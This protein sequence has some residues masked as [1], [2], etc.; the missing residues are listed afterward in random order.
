VLELEAQL[1]RQANALEAAALHATFDLMLLRAFMALVDEKERHLRDAADRELKYLTFMSHDMNNQL[2]AVSLHLRL[3]KDALATSGQQPDMTSI[4]GTVLR[5]IDQT[6]RSMRQLLDHESLRKG[7]LVARRTPVNL[8][9]M[10]NTIAMEFGPL[11]REK[12]LKVA[13]NADPTCEA[14]TDP[15]LIS[16]VLRNLI[17]NAVKYAQRGTIHIQCQSDP[18]APDADDRK[19]SLRIS[20]T[21][22]GPGIAAE[23]LDQIFHAFR[24]AESHGQPGVGLGLAIA[25]QSARLLEAELTVESTP[26]NGS[27]F[28]LRL[29]PA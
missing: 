21:D 14:K 5:G 13:V 28:H 19:R 16:L 22:Q 25:A 4:I 7:S 1:G 15:G 17:G 26:G 10:L 8:G 23:H 9:T 29:P 11:A 20:V 12:D 3:L 24:R 6:A 27:T 18:P 2:S